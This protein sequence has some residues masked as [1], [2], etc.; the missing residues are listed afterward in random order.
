MKAPASFLAALLI[1][2][3]APAISVT[4][5]AEAYLFEV[6]AKSNYYKSWNALFLEEK[7][8]DYWLVQYSK[9]KNGPATHGNAVEL[10]GARFQ[11][12]SVCKAHGCGGNMFYV[13]FAPKGATAWGLLLKEGK[14]ERFF[15]NPDEEKKDVLR[16]WGA[17]S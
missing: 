12:Y 8:V 7:N 11:I 13:L 14:S 9:T 15:G 2:I 10:G 17:Q 6:L 4:A 16:A 5:F 1:A 3:I